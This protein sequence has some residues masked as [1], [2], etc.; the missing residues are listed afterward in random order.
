VVAYHFYK[1]LH[2]V[3]GNSAGLHKAVTYRFYERLLK[4][5]AYRFYKRLHKA[6][7]YCFG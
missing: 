3:L 5:V 6:V 2:I 1:R 4:A 7:A